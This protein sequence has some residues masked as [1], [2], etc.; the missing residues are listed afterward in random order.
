[1]TSLYWFRCKYC[2][3]KQ[4]TQPLKYTN[5]R[6]YYADS[7]IRH[8][9]QFKLKSIQDYLNK[10]ANFKP[11]GSMVLILLISSTSIRGISDWSSF[12]RR[13]GLVGN[14]HIFTKKVLMPVQINESKYSCSIAFGTR[15]LLPMHLLLASW[16]HPNL[17]AF[18]I[19]Q[20]KEPW[21]IVCL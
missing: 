7:I 21:H 4:K 9:K 8:D 3:K 20:A 11:S 6:G 15:S 16:T 10:V 19:G 17:L 2:H 12:A 14:W 13:F 1:V 5:L 18:V